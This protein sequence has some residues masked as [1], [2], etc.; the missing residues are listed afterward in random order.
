MEIA[1]IIFGLI[2]LI[3]GL[4][5]CVIPGIPGP[6]LAYISMLLLQLKEDPPFNL[7]F[8]LIWAGI[9]AV[10]TV[11]DY[12]VP[13]AGAKHFGSSRQGIWGAVLGVIVGVFFFPPVGIIIGPIVGALLGELMA[14]KNTAEAMRSAFGTILGFLTGVLLKLVAVGFMAWY[15]FSNLG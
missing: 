5:G 11:L 8:M 13:A 12:V 14:G 7:K 4:V 2:M 1:I 10:V 9:T 3:A 15:F 6:P